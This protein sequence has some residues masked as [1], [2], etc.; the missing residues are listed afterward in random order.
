MK[1][2][3]ETATILE[4]LDPQTGRAFPCALATV[5][6]VSGSAYR[7]PGARL[8]VDCGGGTLGG[9][10][11]GCLESDVREVALEAIRTGAPRLLHYDTSTDGDTVWGLGLGCEG[12]VDVLV[13]RV[14]DPFRSELVPRAQALLAAATPFAL[15][16]V[17]RGA[18]T[19]RVGL[20]ADGRLLVPT[21]DGALDGALAAEAPGL[22]A[23]GAGALVEAGEA[24]AFCDALRPPPQ[25]LVFGAGDD[26]LPLVRLGLEVGFEVVVVDHRPAFLTPERFPPPA[27]LLRRR[28]EEGLAGLELSPRQVAVVQTHSL[29]HDRAWLRALLAR[30]LGYLGLLGPRRRS[31]EL[32][33]ELGAAPPP[34]LYAPVGLDLGADGPEQVAVSVVAELLA[35]LAGRAPAH[36]RDRAA[37]IHQAAAAAGAVG[38][39]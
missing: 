9:V 8:L 18:A 2:W 30:P 22:L 21:G 36:L 32:L 24:A 37:P 1:H 3:Q 14:D 23:G 28:S 25:L 39:R 27:R 31:Q 7:R 12:A 5:V 16:P 15:L 29:E 20:W 11:G 10:S 6:R 26:A 19:G 34:T 38:P 13:Q 33:R 17:V 35:V 4:R